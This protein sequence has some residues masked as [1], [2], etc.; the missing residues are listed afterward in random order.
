MCAIMCASLVSSFLTLGGS[1]S[2]QCRAHVAEMSLPSA[3]STSHI[4]DAV[5]CH[6]TRLQAAPAETFRLNGAY[7]FCV[8]HPAPSAE[9]VI[10]ATENAHRHTPQVRVTIY[11]S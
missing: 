6:M 1:V 3:V 8:S 4:G 2:G 9:V 10:K 5:L 7:S 11:T